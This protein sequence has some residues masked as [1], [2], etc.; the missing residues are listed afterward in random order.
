MLVFPLCLCVYVCVCVCVCVY[1]V[2]AD[3]GGATPQEAA[4]KLGLSAL[5]AAR[6]FNAVNGGGGHGRSESESE[7][8]SEAEGEG[9]G[10]GEDKG[11]E[12]GDE[13]GKKSDASARGGGAG[14]GNMVEELKNAGN[15]LFGA[16]DYAAAVVKY[17][18]A[19]ELQPGNHTVLSNRSLFFS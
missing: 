3:L 18:A 4:R 9:D 1:I 10:E 13:K 19:L 11:T 16:K 8:E 2:V 5:E 7:S 12:T 6:V 17:S 14:V 15:K